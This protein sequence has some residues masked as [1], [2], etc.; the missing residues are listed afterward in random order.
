ML[1]KI[2]TITATALFLIGCTDS[3]GQSY[4]SSDSELTQIENTIRTDLNN[5]PDY[6]KKMSYQDFNNY[7]NDVLSMYGIDDLKNE[8]FTPEY[9]ATDSK[10]RKLQNAS[11]I[12]GALATSME[13]NY[14]DELKKLRLKYQRLRIQ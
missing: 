7:F 10:G 4:S 14:K 12:L 5:A 11:N 2:I 9:T 8:E 1:K 3:G 13:N 6:F